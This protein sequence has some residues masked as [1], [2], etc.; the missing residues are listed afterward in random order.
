MSMLTLS[1][2]RYSWREGTNQDIHWRE[3]T[4]LVMLDIQNCWPNCL[5][6]CL[7]SVESRYTLKGEGTALVMLA[8]LQNCFYEYAYSLWI[9]LTTLKGR[10]NIGNVVQTAS[11][12]MLTLF[13]SRYT[14]KGRYNIGNVGQTA[15]MSMLLSLNQDIHWREGTTLVM[16]QNCF[17]EYAYSL[18]IY[19]EGKVQLCF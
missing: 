13:E 18:W 16:L 11:M 12:S 10:Y 2:S 4:T 1:E 14:L 3:G 6:V 7:L 17:Y 15:S 8:K 9:K 19:I 5:W